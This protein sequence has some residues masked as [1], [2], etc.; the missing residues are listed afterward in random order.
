M[1]AVIAVS[2]NGRSPVGI[3]LIDRTQERQM[4]LVEV[5]SFFFHAINDG[6]W[7]SK[8]SLSVLF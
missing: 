8:D 2:P 3:L 5:L 7:T 1:G 4:D 6:A